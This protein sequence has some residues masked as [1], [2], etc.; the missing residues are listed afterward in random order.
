MVRR[1]GARRPISQWSSHR[2]GRNRWPVRC[3]GTA[4]PGHGS[5]NSS[6]PA[7]GPGTCHGG[8]DRLPS[9]GG[10]QPGHP[11]PVVAGP[12]VVTGSGNEVLGRDPRTGEVQG[13][14]PETFHRARSA[15]WRWPSTAN[16]T[17]AAK[18]PRLGHRGPR[19]AAQQRRRARHPADRRRDLRRHRLPRVRDV[20][21]DLV[22][23]RSMDPT[24]AGTRTTRCGARTARSPRSCPATTASRWSRSA[25]RNR[26]TG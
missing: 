24:G 1:N 3:G 18:S 17:T 14:T 8:P 7:A 19:P 25:R 2:P 20:A 15:G 22:H 4:T 12:A 5:P 11:E 23:T 26:A 9:S 13:G 21:P 16:R 6:H 10:P